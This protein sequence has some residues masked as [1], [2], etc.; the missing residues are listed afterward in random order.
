MNASELV[1]Q[2]R[3]SILICEAS[4]N[5]L[6][7]SAQTKSYSQRRCLVEHSLRK[8]GILIRILLLNVIPELL[9]PLFNLLGIG[10]H[11]K[12]SGS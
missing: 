5:L 7:S 8:V 2:G 1:E 4:K 11:V 9:L 10:F 12:Y 3:D 6:T